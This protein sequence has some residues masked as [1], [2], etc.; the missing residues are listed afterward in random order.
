MKPN[1]VRSGKEIAATL[2]LSQGTS[3][4]RQRGTSFDRACGVFSYFAQKN[5]LASFLPTNAHAG[6]EI[7]M[8]LA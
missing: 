5:C 3:P 6:T 1:A 7:A 2:L 4:L 8:L